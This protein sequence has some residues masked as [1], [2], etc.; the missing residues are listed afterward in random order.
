MPKTDEIVIGADHE[1]MTNFGISGSWTWRRRSNQN[2]DHLSGV[3]GSDYVQTGTL[4]GNIAPVGPYSIP[5]YSVIPDDVPADFG[6][7]FESRPGYHQ[8]YKGARDRRDQAHVQQL[9]DAHVLVGR[10]EP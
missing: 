2:W 10:R 4:T 9:D 3:T 6:F 5:I 8:T 1:L 7:T